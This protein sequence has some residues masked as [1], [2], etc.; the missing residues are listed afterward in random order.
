MLRRPRVKPGVTELPK[1]ID[2]EI[3]L[4]FRRRCMARRK[5]P[6]H[7]PAGRSGHRRLLGLGRC[8]FHRYRFRMALVLA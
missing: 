3:I 8:R 5:D 7:R 1:F 4:S 2:I 6:G